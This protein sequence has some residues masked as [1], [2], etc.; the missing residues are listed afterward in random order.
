MTDE[1]IPREHPEATTGTLPSDADAWLRFMAAALSAA[2][3]APADKLAVTADEALAE[4]QKRRQP[5]GGFVSNR[6]L[7]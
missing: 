4:Y 7:D 3:H 6:H 1:E 5:D 2:P